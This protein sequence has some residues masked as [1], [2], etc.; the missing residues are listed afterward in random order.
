MMRIGPLFECIFTEA[1]LSGQ[2]PSCVVDGV[3]LGEDDLGD[4]DEGIAVLQELFDD[5]GQGL[6]GVE[7]RV[8]EEHDGPRLH[9]G[10]HPLSNLTGGEA[11][12]IQTVPVRNGFKLL[13]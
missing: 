12:P 8:V 4:G 11:L 5:A 2:L 1:L 10:G 7:G 6:G 13:V 9:L 3:G